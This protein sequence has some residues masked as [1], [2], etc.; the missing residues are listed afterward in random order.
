MMMPSSRFNIHLM[1][2]DDRIPVLNL[3]TKSFFHE[4][5]LAKCLQ[6]G[7]PMD[8]ANNV[9]N[10]TLKDQCSFVGYDIQTNQLAGVCLNKVKYKNDTN[11]IHE[12]NEKLNFILNLL[13]HVHK[14]INLFDH[15][16]TDSLLYIFMINV[17]SNYRGYG[18]A[19]S[20]ISA[21]IEHAKKFHIGGAY[22]EATNIYSLNSFKQQ[23]FQIYDQLNYVEYDQV[24]LA[25]LTD[26]SYDQ[27]QLVART[28]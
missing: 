14:N 19:S 21:S 12:P 8:F 1:T 24:R 2:E 16:L 22:A 6:L 26:K 20:L 27:C 5:P 10:D 17:D 3:L 23:G 7:E 4:E 18:L 13:H 15:F 9:I 25:N 28:L 11:T